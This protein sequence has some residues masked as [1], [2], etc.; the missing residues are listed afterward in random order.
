MTKQGDVTINLVQ[1]GVPVPL[2]N[3]SSAGV[4]PEAR[5]AA[6]AQMEE[7]LVLVTSLWGGTP[8]WL[9]ASACGD[10]TWCDDQHGSFSI[11]GLVVD[12]TPPAPA[13]SHDFL[14]GTVR[15]V[16]GEGKDESGFVRKEAEEEDEEA[17]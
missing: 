8:A 10:R 17:A 6:A 14:P 2:F 9:G 1:D 3:R 13:P 12:G 5:S 4:P 11:S 15:S 7:G 16:P